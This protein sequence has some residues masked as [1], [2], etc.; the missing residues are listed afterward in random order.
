[1][2]Q[3]SGLA[4]LARRFPHA[5][6]RLDQP[7]PG[8]ILATTASA[9]KM[10]S[11]SDGRPAR[12]NGLSAQKTTSPV[13][14]ILAIVASALAA[15]LLADLVCARLAPGNP[16]LRNVVDAILSVLLIIPALYVWTFRPVSKHIKELNQVNSALEQRL[17]ELKQAQE[18]QEVS[19]QQLRAL[20]AGLEAVREEE[21]THLAR[22]IH[23]V[24][25]QDLT[26]LKL[27]LAW[28]DRR[29]AQSPEIA[30]QAPVHEKLAGM[31]RL[32]DKAIESVQ[33]IATELR[34]AVLD[35][36]GLAAAIEWQITDFAARTGIQFK[37]S[38][39]D[40]PLDLG[41]EASTALF[42]IL[43]ESLTNVARHAAATA[44]ETSLQWQPGQVVLRVK[45]NGRGMPTAK[46][47]DPHSVGLAGMRERA[48]LLGGRCEI[49]ARPGE[50]TA[51]EVRLPLPSTVPTGAK[52]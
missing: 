29:L 45:D 2:G 44:V 36:L 41:R 31:T 19:R 37:T 4:G 17:A 20:A 47:E 39:P 3:V 24:L 8:H 48:L 51:I 46:L 42:R 26:L 43:Q 12:W 15:E 11:L 30:R 10:N 1:M 40:G 22:E 13:Q 28:L 25:A 14:L 18:A 33:R 32:T 6:Y 49:R 52:L 21:R 27:D 16:W 9:A 38:L 5:K 34:P 50:G 23:D 35:S 7:L